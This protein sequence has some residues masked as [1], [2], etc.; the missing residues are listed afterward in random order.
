M[1]IRAYHKRETWQSGR[2]DH[3]L[4]WIAYGNK[5][6]V[7]F[8]VFVYQERPEYGFRPFQLRDGRWATPGGVEVHHRPSEGEGGNTQGCTVLG[9]PCNH[10]GSSLAASEFCEDWHWR[11]DDE[12]VWSLLESWMR[13]RDDDEPAERSTV[14]EQLKAVTEAQEEA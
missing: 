1:K 13:G 2:A 4:S 14:M 10:D 12:P 9:G 5:V 7:E 6:A 8:W 3:R 11:G